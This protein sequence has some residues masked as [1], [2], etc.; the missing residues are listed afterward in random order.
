M[1]GA[2]QPVPGPAHVAPFFPSNKTKQ[3]PL[4]GTRNHINEATNSLDWAST[5]IHADKSKVPAPRQIPYT[6]GAVDGLVVPDGPS[7]VPRLMTPELSIDELSTGTG[8]PS[9]VPVP[10]PCAWVCSSP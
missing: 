10:W 8:V 2:G 6:P 5:C 4:L 1:H 7:V 3:L 9:P